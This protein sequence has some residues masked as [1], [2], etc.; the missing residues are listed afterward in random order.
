VGR[1]NGTDEPVFQHEFFHTTSVTDFKV[2]QKGSPPPGYPERPSPDC[3]TALPFK[4]D[5]DDRKEAFL[6]HCLRNP[7]ANTIKGY[8]YELAR[9]YKNRGP[10]YCGAI[11]GALDYIN[12]RF[13]C[14]DFVLLGIIRILYQFSES[15]LLETG[16]LSRAKKTVLGFKYWPD[17][18]GL[19]SMCYWTENHQIMFLSSEYLAGQ[20]YP[21]ETFTNSGMTGQEKMSHARPRILQW[22]ELRFKTGFS[23]WLSHIYYDEDITALVNLVDF[24]RDQDISVRASIVL[25]LLL[26]DLALNSYHGAFGSSH[27]RSYGAEKKNALVESTIDTAKLLFGVGIFSGSDNMSA[28]TLAV[29][30]QYRLPR[31]IYEVAADFDRPE[32]INRQRMSIKIGEALRWGLN[33]DDLDSGMVFLSL[34]A[35]THPRTIALTMKMFDAY[36][37]WENQFF[38]MFKAKK[39]LIAFLRSFRLLGLFARVFEKDITRN[40]REEVNLYTYKTPDYMLSA[41]QDY[42]AG[43][44][45]DQQHIWQAT[46]SPEAV[47][48][49]THPGK[50][51]DS[52]GGY[53]VGSGNLPRVALVKNVLVAV[54]RISR[55]PGIYL[56]NRLYFTHAWFPRD[57]F[58]EVVEKAG[59]VFG[60]KNDGYIALRSQNSYRWQTGGKDAGREIIAGGL[61]NIWLCEMGRKEVDGG[62]AAFVDKISNAAVSFRG[63]AVAYRS[64]S[65]GLLEFGWSGELKQEGKVVGLD[66]YPRYDNPYTR[67]D[68]PPAKIVIEHS[69]ER[70]E[71]NIADPLRQSSRYI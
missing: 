43:Y 18:P 33:Y 22:L 6:E 57:C 15:D 64:P 11:D 35:Y 17:E 69:A 27:G 20:L 34:E 62:F 21:E 45:G 25:D 67:A 51:D 44:G 68:F 41:A 23:E 48:F 4:E 7:A 39:K 58:D 28:V 56:T 36:R 65:Q 10:V 13:D 49:T 46:L 1:I 42:R 71:L 14:S 37:W 19:D 8:Y 50:E 31:V 30:P 3:Y 61:Q 5:F 24:C 66:D 53:W 59:W 60:R 55:M 52:S 38:D 70:L 12:N 47:C 29:S 2:V 54:Y 40:T 32:L 9:L 16:L 63:Q 26:Y